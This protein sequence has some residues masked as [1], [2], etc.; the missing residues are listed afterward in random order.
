MDEIKLREA[1][2]KIKN[3]MSNLQAELSLL[4]LEISEIK[5][6]AL[7]NQKT[8]K[9]HSEP[10]FPMEN[11]DTTV[12]QINTT[13]TVTTT[14]NT[15]VPQE[16]EG[17]K[18]PNLSSSTGNRGVTTDRQTHSQTDR[19]HEIPQK[20]EVPNTLQ[21][22]SQF[23][24]SLDNLKKD[25]KI[26]FKKVT[27]QEMVVFS[28]IYQLEEQNPGTVTYKNISKSVH[29]SES[30]IRDYVGRMINKGIPINKEKINNKQL[31]L[32]ISPSLKKI[33]NLSTIIQ[34]RAL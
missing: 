12:R 3:E 25:I 10:S 34:L 17:L 22:T 2:T 20:N 29:L 32:S 13:D 21:D 18:Y 16:I 4:R 30:S 27:N 19:F 7:S 31:I 15:T 14:D 33:A 9:S 24:E 11:E 23:L 8:P 26:K 28:S 5:D 1:F 6:I